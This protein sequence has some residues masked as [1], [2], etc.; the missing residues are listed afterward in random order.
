MVTP[1]ASLSKSLLLSISLLSWLVSTPSSASSEHVTTTHEYDVVI[2]GNTVAALAAAMQTTR[3]K[4]SVTIVLPGYNLGGLTT[5]GLGW[6]D[7]KDGKT[8]GGIAREFYEKIFTYYQE[9]DAWTHETREKYISKRIAAQ[10]GPA[11]DKSNKVQWTFEPK[12]AENIWDKWIKDEDI[13]VFRNKTIDRS[14][15]S[16]V[17]DGSRIVSFRTLAG[18]IFSANMFINAGYE[19][20]LMETAGIPYR[21]GRESRQEHRESAAGVLIDNKDRFPRLDPYV[22][23]ENSRS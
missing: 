15:E 2:Y 17:K 13:P 20:D 4:K 11:I 14:K 10:P 3:M 9:T 6:T 8:I 1:L 22:E 19:G 5:S 18:S 12:V 7:S 21:V 23:R 16:L